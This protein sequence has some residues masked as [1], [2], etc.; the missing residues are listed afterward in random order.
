MSLSYCCRPAA[1]LVPF[2]LHVSGQGAAAHGGPGPGL[3]G[4]NGEGRVGGGG[5]GGEG[6]GSGL[7]GQVSALPQET[8][9]DLIHV[10]SVQQKSKN[11][12]LRPS[13]LL[14]TAVA[15]VLFLSDL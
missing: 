5:R 13:L 1:L 9:A 12:G 4:E 7:G 10:P 8:A 11:Y 15:A 14:S 3:G 2:R 6:R